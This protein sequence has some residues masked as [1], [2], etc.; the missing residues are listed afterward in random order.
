[1]QAARN[2]CVPGSLVFKGPVVESDANAEK[3]PLPEGAAVPLEQRA[4]MPWA[5][6]CGAVSLVGRASG[7][8]TRMPFLFADGAVFRS[9]CQAARVSWACPNSRA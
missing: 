1:M 8:S 9:G 2:A 4:G 5:A 6:F 3:A 7:F